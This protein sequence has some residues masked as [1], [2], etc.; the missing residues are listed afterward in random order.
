MFT[1]W[2]PFLLYL[3]AAKQSKSPVI[4]NPMN[5]SFSREGVVVTQGTERLELIWENIGRVERIQGMMIVYMGKVR[6]YLLP[7]F[8]Y[9][10]EEGG[11]V[12]TVPGESAGGAEKERYKSQQSR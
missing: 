9:R 4:Q 3:K 11:A 10:R 7:G 5:L 1:V 2:Q 12:G 6:A 8:H